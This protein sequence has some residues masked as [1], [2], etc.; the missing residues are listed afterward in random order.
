MKTILIAG[1]TGF[2]GRKIQSLL[3]EKGYLINI[4]TRNPKLK[5]EFRWD[6]EQKQIDTKAFEN[7]VSIINL[8]G[9]NIG[10][11]RWS[12]K[13]K[14]EL[15]DSRVE[16]TKFLYSQINNIPHL[17]S[18][19]S[20]SGI[21]CYGFEDDTKTYTEED[22]FGSDYLSQLVKDWENAA[23][24]FK[25]HC[26]VVKMRTAVVLDKVQ[27]ALPKISLPIRLGIGSPIGTGKQ[28]TSWIHISDLINSY[29]YAI[30][31]PLKGAFNI[32]GGNES[33]KEFSEKL[34]KTLD[35]PF[36]FPNVPAF[37]LKL[38]LGEMSI[39]L[40][41]GNTASNQKIIESGFKFQ[42]LKIEDAF[43]DLYKKELK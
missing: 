6:L 29:L 24:L 22:P 14:K 35:K 27:G 26:R 31:N 7:V 3:E 20:A 21:T 41:K 37:V 30:E 15:L 5:N 17:E 16:T 42:F 33:N 43:E 9:A 38:L 34:A 8:C 1:G 4:L 18:Y 28:S 11:K 32:V 13:R 2:I 36:W 19:I 23:D 12:T 10:E 39:I 25:T 40:L